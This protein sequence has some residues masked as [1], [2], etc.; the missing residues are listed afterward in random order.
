MTL[1]HESE[2]V[3]DTMEFDSKGRFLETIDLQGLP[4]TATSLEWPPYISIE[5]CSNVGTNCSKSGY[6]V[7]FMDIWARELNFTWDIYADVNNSWGLDPIEGTTHSCLRVSF[8]SSVRKCFTF[9]IPF[10]EK[11]QVFMFGIRVKNS[12]FPQG[13]RPTTKDEHRFSVYF[14]YPGQRFTSI[15]TIKYDWEPKSNRSNPY[16]MQYEMKDVEVNRHRIRPQEPC[17]EDWKNYDQILMDKIMLKAGCRPSHWETARNFSLCSNSE[18][19]AYFVDQPS[20]A[21]VEA[22]GPPCTVIENLHYRYYEE[23][24][25]NQGKF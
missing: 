8:R 20:T 7:E 21:T 16:H 25:S 19:M 10:L 13:V 23:E 3:V 18:Q 12:F 4:I 22:F 6:L 17:I 1:N 2:I 9:D 11:K 15:Y 14:H 5:N 24:Y